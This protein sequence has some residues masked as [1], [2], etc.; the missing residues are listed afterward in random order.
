MVFVIYAEFWEGFVWVEQDGQHTKASLFR[1]LVD[2]ARPRTPVVHGVNTDLSA[3]AVRKGCTHPA[4][5][6]QVTLHR[7]RV[8]RHRAPWAM[9]ITRRTP[10]F[11]PFTTVLPAQNPPLQPTHQSTHCHNEREQSYPP[12]G[13]TMWDFNRQARQPGLENC[14]IESTYTHRKRRP[15]PDQVD[16]FRLDI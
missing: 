12:T 2:S 16:V 11:L 8:W 14:S 4:W 5:H 15:P 7:V 1:S 10:C 3:S 13:P 9:A 6:W